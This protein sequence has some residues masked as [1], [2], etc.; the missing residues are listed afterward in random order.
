MTF[1]QPVPSQPVATRFVAVEGPTGV[2]KSTVAEHLRSTWQG[3]LF[4]F[5]EGFQ[6]FRRE[7]RLDERVAPLPRLAYYLGGVLELSDMV[8]RE[9]ATRDVVCDRYLASP[10]ALIEV[11]GGIE[12]PAI[13][14]SGEPLWRHVRPPDVT[15]L[16][17]ARHDVAVGRMGGR[18]RA[19]DAD[20][21]HRGAA[22]SAGFFDAWVGALRRYA[23]E[24]GPV[25]ELDTSDLDEAGMCEAAIDAVNGALPSPGG[26]TP[27]RP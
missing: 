17:T 16:L 8:G 22:T 10:L 26:S 21:A 27:D 19:T 12:P 5:P 7:A 14:S 25:V 24:L 6:R 13:R 4:H 20:P 23:T 9:L 15:L 3:A 1:R 2:G 18:A 11:L